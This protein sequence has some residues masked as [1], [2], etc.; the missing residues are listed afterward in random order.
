M[1][2]PKPS[3]MAKLIAPSYISAPCEAQPRPCSRTRER[4]R[5]SFSHAR[6]NPKMALVGENNARP[7]AARARPSRR[8]WPNQSHPSYIS[9]PARRSHGHALVHENEIEIRSPIRERTPKWLSWV[10]TTPDHPP[11]AHAQAVDHGHN[12]RLKLYFAPCPG[13]AATMFSYTRA[14]SRFTLT[15]ESEPQNGSRR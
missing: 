13:V 12:H 1:R 8:S 3:V 2:T 14:K 10:R 4:N 11:R 7:S 6:A 5:D 9:A 15:G